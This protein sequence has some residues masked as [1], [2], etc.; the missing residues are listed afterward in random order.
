MAG[1]NPG[2]DV[3][4]NFKTVFKPGSMGQLGDFAVGE[5]KYIDKAYID[6]MMAAR[7][8]LFEGITSE[9][10]W[11]PGKVAI[12][13]NE[14]MGFQYKDGFTPTAKL[15][16]MLSG[17]GLNRMG[18]SGLEDGRTNA[19]V[20]SQGNLVY[21]DKP[22]SYQPAKE[23]AKS[24]AEA[25]ALAAAAF[26]GI[27][28]LGH[29]PL[30]GLMGGTGAGAGVGELAA[31]NAAM[32]A[33]MIDAAA[34]S[35]G[36][37]GSVGLGSGAGAGGLSS[38]GGLGG[39]SIDSALADI[40][41]SSGTLAPEG[42][43]ALIPTG[44]ELG[45]LGGGTLLAGGLGGAPGGGG[46]LESLLGK[47][48]DKAA[49]T[50][51][52]QLKK[53]LPGGE[54]GLG[55]LAKYLLPALA[56]Y[57]SYKDAKQPQL[58]GYSGS[59]TPRTATQTVEQGKY[60]PISRTKYAAGGIAGAGVPR[61]LGSADDGMQDGIK[62]HIDGEE[63]AALSG[64]EFVIPA[65]VVSHIGNGNSNAGAKQLFAMMDRIRSARTGTS[66]QGKQINPNR[67]MPV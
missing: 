2:F 28:A 59:I 58:Q 21:A 16:E 37:W 38:L 29:G 63:P 30:A 18:A 54:G 22:Y 66:E 4:K 48:G 53:L 3:G 1:Y 19:L 57:A 31:Q 14:E 47:V 26:G 33:A 35:A 15:M 51:G 32:D 45:T 49:G 34:G 62:A 6:R 25:A 7:P 10:L 24:L 41:A 11:T 8:D 50:I 9:D 36:G 61:Y 46:I 42:V 44:A 5:N 56:G 52:S 40:I 27:G 13:G 23:T 65:D 17:Y 43:A 60:G 39:G 12:G 20:D 55:D 64:G 67:F